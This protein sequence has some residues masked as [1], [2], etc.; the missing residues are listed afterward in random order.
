[1]NEEI[2]PPPM[3]ESEVQRIMGF[4]GGIIFVIMNISK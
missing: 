3:A 1:M 4:G 2:I